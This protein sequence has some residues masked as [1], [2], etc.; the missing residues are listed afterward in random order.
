MSSQENFIN[1]VNNISTKEDNIDIQIESIDEQ[2]AKINIDIDG[3]NYGCEKTKEKVEEVLVP[4]GDFLHTFNNYFNGTI[5][6]DGPPSGEDLNLT[7]WI[8]FDY[9]LDNLDSDPNN[10]YYSGHPSGYDTTGNE[11]FD[12]GYNVA[13]YCKGNRSA[14]FIANPTIAAQLVDT[15]AVAFATVTCVDYWIENPSPLLD[16]TIINIT[17]TPGR[18]GNTTTWTSAN[19]KRIMKIVFEKDGTG[20]TSD[21]TSEIEIEKQ[22]SSFLYIQDYVWAPLSITATY[23]LKDMIAKLNI[24][25]QITQNNK[26]KISDGTYELGDL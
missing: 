3:L 17:L 18:K 19:V 6:Q 14:V 1:F 5:G 10:N 24:G 9:I 25:K 4:K 13:F 12:T 15:T 20:W 7:D 23:G 2:I 22:I 16:Y 26:T 21:G 8:V 11:C